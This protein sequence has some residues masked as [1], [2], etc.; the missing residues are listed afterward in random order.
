MRN[1]TDKIYNEEW[2]TKSYKTEA[3]ATKAVDKAYNKMKANYPEDIQAKMD[4]SFAMFNVLLPSGR[5]KPVITVGTGF[6]QE[7]IYLVHDGFQVIIK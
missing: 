3:N 1:I 7:G 5:Y 6:G 4:S 2:F